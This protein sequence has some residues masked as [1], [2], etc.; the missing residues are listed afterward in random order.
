MPAK[1]EPRMAANDGKDSTAKSSPPRLPEATKPDLLTI[2]AIAIVATV[3]ADFIHEGLGHGGMC[4]ATGGQPLVL[5]TAHFECSAD[6]R[7][8]AAAGTLANLAVGTLSWVAIRAVKQFPPWRY[9]F[10]LLMTLN[11]FGVGGYFLFSGVGNIGDWAAV[12]AGWQPAWAWR[13]GLA[14]L[15]I[16]TYF[17]LFVPLSLRELRPFLGK[18]REGPRAAGSPV[19]ARALSHWRDPLLRCRR[20]KSGRAA[21]DSDLRRGCVIRWQLRAG[22]DVDPALRLPHPQQ[23][24]PDAQNRT[25]SGM[26]HRRSRPRDRVHHGTGARRK[27]SFCPASHGHFTVGLIA[28]SYQI[29]PKVLF[30]SAP[31]EA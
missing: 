14:A 11:L 20:A 13:V 15:G 21:V 28:S 29:H 23:R 25:Q 24:I 10:W 26:D 30:A 9:F 7:L 6:T 27:V 2:V 12:V 17:F 1:T 16:V 3:I 4:V 8:V 22:L 31:A 18:G 19:H 5:S